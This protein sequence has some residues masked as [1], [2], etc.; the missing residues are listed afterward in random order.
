MPYAPLADAVLVLHVAIAAF[1]VAGLPLIVLGR[2][3]RWRWVDRRGFRL[4][5]LG[6]IGIVVAEAWSGVACPLT[7][8]EAALR[9]RAGGAGYAGGFVEHWLQR[10]LY[11]DAAPW[12]FVLGYSVFGLLVAAAWWLLPPQGGR[13]LWPRR[14]ARAPRP[15]SDTRP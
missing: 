3:A 14:T 9:A 7:T 8:L 2:A 5:H 4:A 15:V 10:L 12:V 13:S 11:Y 6:A 1:V